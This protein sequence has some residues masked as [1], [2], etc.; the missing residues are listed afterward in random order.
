MEALQVMAGHLQIK[1]RINPRARRSVRAARPTNTNPQPRLI[2][3]LPFFPVEKER[4]KAK[5]LEKLAEK[6]SGNVGA[7]NAGA[8]SKAKERKAKQ[9]AAKD[10]PAPAYH[11]ETPPG[12]KKSGDFPALDERIYSRTFND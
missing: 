7:T 3:A 4:K 11:E 10:E 6:Q 12:Q 8:P 9:D 2:D 1:G 5:K